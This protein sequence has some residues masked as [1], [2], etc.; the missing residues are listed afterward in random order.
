LG[1]LGTFTWGAKVGG[2]GCQ[3]IGKYCGGEIFV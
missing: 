2:G 3:G 1:A